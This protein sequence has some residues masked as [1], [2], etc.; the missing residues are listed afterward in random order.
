MI[1]R[2]VSS[3]TLILWTIYGHLITVTNGQLD[4][5]FG[6]CIYQ[7]ENHQEISSFHPPPP[8]Y[9]SETIANNEEEEYNNNDDYNNGRLIFNG[10][11]TNR[12][13]PAQPKKRTVICTN[14]PPYLRSGYTVCGACWKLIYKNSNISVIPTNTHQDAPKLEELQMAEL[15]IEKIQ[16]GAFANL[17]SLEV[18]RLEK[19]KLKKI[20]RG[21]F[22][23]IMNLRYLNL[24]HNII[25]E[26]EEESFHGSF[27]IHIL[28]L[29]FNKIRSIENIFHHSK[30]SL[31]NISNNLLA[32]IGNDFCA[33]VPQ[34]TNLILDHNL[35]TNIPACL[36]NS[37]VSH[38]SCNFNSI[39][40]L[41]E[42]SFPRSLNILYIGSN[43]IK[44]MNEDVFASLS[45][46]Q[47]L[48]ISCNALERIAPACFK[49]FIFLEGLDL[50]D[51]NLGTINSELFSSMKS[52]KELRMKKNHINFL[53]RGVFRYLSNLTL[54]DLSEN[55]ITFLQSGVLKDLKSLKFLYLSHNKLEFLQS[56]VL[57]GM[58]MLNSIDLSWNRLE[59]LHFYIFNPLINLLTLDLKH[60]QIEK[61][62]IEH[63]RHRKYVL[64]VELDGN[65][66]TCATLH[67]IKSQLLFNKIDFISGQTFSSENIDGISC[68]D[69]RESM[70]ER[71]TED[72]MAGMR[73]FFQNDFRNT[74]FYNFF[75]NFPS[76]S[77]NNASIQNLERAVGDLQNNLTYGFSNSLN[78][79]V[80]EFIR[81]E[82][83]SFGNFLKELALIVN[84]LED[85]EK[86]N[87]SISLKDLSNTFKTEIKTFVTFENSSFQNFMN[88]LSDIVDKMVENQNHSEH[89]PDI[90][91]KVN[92]IR[93]DKLMYS[94][95]E[96]G[97]TELI[98]AINQLKLFVVMCTFMVIVLKIFPYA[99]KK[100]LRAESSEVQ[101]HEMPILS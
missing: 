87:E 27:N 74:S 49:D 10:F 19:N 83:A 100:Y 13:V 65:N 20:V 80:K 31:L 26:I 23:S 6:D 66:F 58:E 75:R 89:I 30:L 48:D 37:I 93:A 36:K 3:H 24:S 25:S 12:E 73:Y 46:L 34:L 16:A 99:K 33:S 52:L 97:T 41:N 56:G 84:R 18:L 51:I 54:L 44:Q 43:R 92:E 7:E 57:N 98:G 82:N 67:Q 5:G 55:G 88:R 22:N 11:P 81:F 59:S 45:N 71:N 76:T 101:I 69:D 1:P 95:E 28:D 62:F 47:G 60:N 38:L 64:A 63:Q 39:A 61:L 70:L 86:Q 14:A 21:T 96:N 94:K 78:A 40:F 9:G 90:I 42:S 53:Q 4:S 32:T 2:K 50:S 68:K 72:I 91:E 77:N 29:S 85:T 79:H 8:D 35:L 15:G 17:P